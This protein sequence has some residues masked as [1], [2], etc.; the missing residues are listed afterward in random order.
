[1]VYLDTN[2]LVYASV[3]QDSRK[4]ETALRLIQSL[5]SRSELQ[6]SVLVLQE[7]VFTM[8]KLAA[9]ENLIKSDFE[10]YSRFIAWE[11]AP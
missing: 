7:F 4:K 8:A 5:A 6:L 9:D 2:V 3:E 11:V 1:M 10:Y